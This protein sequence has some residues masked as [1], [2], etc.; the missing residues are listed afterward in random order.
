[1]DKGFGAFLGFGGGAGR[2]LGGGGGRGRGIDWV[3]AFDGFFFFFSE[4][5]VLT[6]SMISRPL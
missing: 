6:D 5:A 3:E 4:R 2:A 1:M